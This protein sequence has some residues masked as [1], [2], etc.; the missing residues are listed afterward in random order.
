[1][2]PW[3]GNLCLLKETRYNSPVGGEWRTQ[4]LQAPLTEPGHSPEPW[5]AHDVG[6]QENWN[7]SIQSL[8][9]PR[10][11]VPTSYIKTT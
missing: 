8:G 10:H 11:P 6:S 1:M 9:G 3:A 7:D 2:L 5:L 4:H